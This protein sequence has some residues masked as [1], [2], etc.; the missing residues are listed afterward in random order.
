[1]ETLKKEIYRLV[2]VGVLEEV[3]PV[4]APAWCAP[5]FIIP[6][7]DNRVRVITDYRELNKR[8][9]RKPWPMPHITDMLQDIG[10]Y[11]YVTAIDLSM[12]FYHF[13]LDQAAQDMSTFMVPFGL[14]KFRR[15]PMGLSVSPDIF[16][17]A[18]ARLF[19]DCPNVKV[20]MDDL[21]IFS[22]GSFEDHLEKVNEA[23]DRLQ[24]QGMAV[25]A[26]KSFWAV[27]EVDYLGFRLTQQGVKPQMKKVKAILNLKAPKNK[28]EL[29]RFIGMINYYRFMWRKRSEILTPLTDLTKKLTVFRWTEKHQKAFEEMKRTLC[30]E[31]L[32]S[33]QEIQQSIPFSIPLVSCSCL[34]IEYTVFL[35]WSQAGKKFGLRKARF[36]KEKAVLNPLLSNSENIFVVPVFLFCSG[37]F[38]T[39]SS[40]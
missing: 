37:T 13:L 12:G 5:T 28:R 4:R 40:T 19:V 31:E 34:Q 10:Q 15:L 24:K 14:F 25:N 8:I 16:Q 23:L 7:K 3:D 27:K 1:L 29:R 2:E 38:Q 35:E 33:F 26:E 32:L 6:K 9:K 20:Y 21:L 11:T 17:G 36:G 22:H 30:K 18:M 39:T